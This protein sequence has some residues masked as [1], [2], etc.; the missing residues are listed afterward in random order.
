MFLFLS[1]LLPLFVYPPGLSS[2][3]LVTALLARRKRPR[4]ATAAT[5]LALAVLLLG[6]NRWIALRLARSLEWQ[7]IPATPP[8]RAE[9]IVVLGG[10]L[11]PAFPPRP[12]VQ[13]TEPGSRILYAAKLYREGTAPL[14]IVSGGTV[15]PD[16]APE[17]ADMAEMLKFTGVPD[18]AIVLES[19]SLNTY[20]NAVNVRQVLDSRGI[21]RILLVTSAMHMPRALLIF[22]HQGVEA[23]PAPV[24]FIATARDF[25]GSN[26][27]LKAMASNLL[28]D[29]ESLEWTSRA[30]KEY[31]GLA[32]YRLTGRL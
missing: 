13:L 31:L 20:E 11:E 26:N 29:A 23:L 5:M 19:N 9:A 6:G 24:D 10:G 25:D 7:N 18:S 3:L 32:V 17:A 22:K 16:V 12:W 8:P 14:V 27:S 28:P 15:W 1:K 30:M 4:L 21:H 2:V